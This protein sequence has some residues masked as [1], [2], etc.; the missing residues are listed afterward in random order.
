MQYQFSPAGSEYAAYAQNLSLWVQT[1]I[2]QT[3]FPSAIH[4]AIH[5]QVYNC[6]VSNPNN[7]ATIEDIPTSL[8]GAS[9]KTVVIRCSCS[10]IAGARPINVLVKIILTPNFPQSAPK[11]TIEPTPDTAGLPIAHHDYLQGNEIR[12]PYLLSWN[13]YSQPPSNLTNLMKFIMNTIIAKNP[14]VESSQSV[15]VS[16]GYPAP[17]YGAA[18]V[19]PMYNSYVPRSTAASSKPSAYY[20]PPTATISNPGSSMPSNEPY[21]NPTGNS[22]NPGNL[23]S[24]PSPEDEKKELL[25][26]LSRSMKESTKTFCTT[27]AQ[28]LEHL[29]KVEYSLNLNSQALSAAQTQLN[30][31]MEAI[32][33][34]IKELEVAKPKLEQS[35]S[36]SERISINQSNVLEQV[37]PADKIQDKWLLY[38]AK[39]KAIEDVFVQLKKAADEKVISLSELVERSRK[40]GS[41][42]MSYIFKKKRLEMVQRSIKAGVKK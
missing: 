29:Q 30:G 34:A 17:H 32:K 16:G 39:I 23:P 26:K 6:L 8:P 11:V 1:L 4:S 5:M 37:K 40:L 18:S 33:A 15:F 38:D 28:T 24:V 21:Y 31:K 22:W 13:Q 3:Q 7:K 35:L 36:A 41:K 19:P 20:V 42:Q 12:I 25:E 10:L 27:A 2:M 9:F 14:Y